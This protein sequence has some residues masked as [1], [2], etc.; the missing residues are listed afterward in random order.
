M[1]TDSRKRQKQ[2]AKKKAKRKSVVETKKKAAGA[3]GGA[4]SLARQM[5]VTQNAPVHECLVP[6]SLSVQGMANVIF[7]RKLG[8]GEFA[9]SCFLLDTYC[10]G[11]KNAFFTIIDESQYAQLKAQTADSNDSKL[12]NVHPACLR[13]LVEGAEAY[14]KSIGFNPHINYKLAKQIFADID[15]SVCPV[16]Y[17]YG[18]NG[19]PCYFPG[20]YDDQAKIRKI[21]ATLKRNCGEGNY[22][23]IIRIKEPDGFFNDFDDKFEDDEPTRR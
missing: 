8:G 4:L 1:A 10:L 11:V 22:D 9:V 17:E 6:E 7:S 13:K 20:P 16:R 23:V 3:L 12:E 18:R 21:E 14:A 19:R 2:L 5:L 15:A